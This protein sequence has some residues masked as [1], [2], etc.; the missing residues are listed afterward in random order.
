MIFKQVLSTKISKVAQDD[1]VIA[2]YCPA[3]A[4]PVTLDHGGVIDCSCG[5]MAT[6]DKCL[7]N[8]K[9][10][11]GSGQWICEDK[12]R[13]EFINVNILSCN[14]QC[15]KE[16]CKVNYNN[17]GKRALSQCKSNNFIVRKICRLSNFFVI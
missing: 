16:V 13:G 12:F 2:Y 3:C 15:R 11:C 17:T 9:V 14:S 8:E 7:T 5:L 1:L 6:K 10:V 4:I